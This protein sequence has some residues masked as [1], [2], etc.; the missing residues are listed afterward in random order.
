MT[1][2]EVYDIFYKQ[3]AIDYSCTEEEIRDFNNYVKIDEHRINTRA[4]KKDNHIAKMISLNGKFIL[5]V[6]ERIKE[7]ADKLISYK[8]EWMSLGQHAMKLNE[9]TQP[10]GYSAVDQHHYYLPIGTPRLSKND[11]DEMKKIYKITLYEKDELERFRGDGRFT[12]ALTFVEKAPDMLAITA[13][14]DGEILGMSGASADSDTMWQIGINVFEK[15]R[16]KNIGPMLTILLKEEIL[17]RGKLPFYGTAESHIQS[18]RVGLKS[19][20]WPAWW[21]SYSYESGLS[22]N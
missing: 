7:E 19:G 4:Y 10:Y 8:G 17:E 3:M 18:Q 16:G 9:I 2:K 5:S 11:I 13:E 6:D 14:A 20:F 12:S 21:E 15:A 22:Y 1:T